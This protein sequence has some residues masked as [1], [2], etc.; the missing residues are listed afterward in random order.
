MHLDALSLLWMAVDWVTAKGKQRH[1]R[2]RYILGAAFSIVC[3][4]MLAMAY[5]KLVPQSFTSEWSMILPGSGS[6]TRVAL[7]RIG[8]AQS[9]SASPFSEKSLSPKVNYKEIAESLPVLGEAARLVDVE[10]EEFDKPKIK[11]IDQT[12]IILVSMAGPTPEEAQRRSLALFEAFKKRLDHLREDEIKTKNQAVRTNIADVEIGLKLARQRLLELQTRTGLSSLEQYNQ[13]VASIEAMR[14]E[15]AGAR[16]ALAERKSQVEQLRASL[17]LTPEQAAAIIR[18]SANPE[19]RRLA[20]AFSVA[21]ATFAEMRERMGEVHPRVVDQRG[22]VDSILTSIRQIRPE[23]L[24]G[25]PQESFRA[26]LPS[27]SERFVTMLTDYVTRN[28]EVKGHEARV[29]E[30]EASLQEL[31]ARRTRLGAIAAQ[32][33]DLQR[34]HLIANAV[35]SSALARIDAGKSDQYAS[36]PVV[37]MLSEPTLPDRPSSPR[38]L[39]AL[40]GAV[41]GSLFSTLGWTFAWLHQWFLFQRLQNRLFPGLGDPKGMVG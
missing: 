38:L 15:N 4:N 23:G 41:L 36:Y 28:A 26:L 12:S 9:T 25:V 33:D 11:L 13:L 5:L 17:G 8:Q 3:C 29:A 24:E 37:Q 20:Q 6:E 35:F 30:L 1:H 27:E 19:L 21:N 14:R 40:L 31:E 39:F 18:I 2:R 16:A 22:R 32:L 10:P 7:D 34:D